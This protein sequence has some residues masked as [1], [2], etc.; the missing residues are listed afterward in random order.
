L[1][2]LLLLLLSP[3]TRSSCLEPAGSLRF[4]WVSVEAGA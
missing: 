2:L 3:I 1:L 4:E